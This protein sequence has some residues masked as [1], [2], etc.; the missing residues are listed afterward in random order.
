MKEG[1]KI[2]IA[3]IKAN[4]WLVFHINKLYNTIIGKGFVNG[5]LQTTMVAV[6]KKFKVH[7]YFYLRHR[8]L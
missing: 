2:L 7:K 4:L 3:H 5:K 8:N 1:M 6:G